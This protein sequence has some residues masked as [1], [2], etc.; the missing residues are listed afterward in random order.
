MM[1]LWDYTCE[2]EIYTFAEAG[3]SAGNDATTATHGFIMT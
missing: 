1:N 3:N 2:Y